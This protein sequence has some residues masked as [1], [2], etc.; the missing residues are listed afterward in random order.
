MRVI[1]SRGDDPVPDDPAGRVVAKVSTTMAA[2]AANLGGLKSLQV[3]ATSESYANVAG[4]AG[5]LD[6]GVLTEEEREALRAASYRL[7]AWSLSS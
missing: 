4:S 2:G 3:G 1:Y 6:C 7:T 5:A